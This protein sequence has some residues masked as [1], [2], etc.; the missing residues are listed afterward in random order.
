MIRSKHAWALAITWTLAALLGLATASFIAYRA[1]WR[2]TILWI[3]IGVSVAAASLLTIQLVRRSP[4]LLLTF[5]AI[6]AGGTMAVLKI[7]SLD[8]VPSIWSELDDSPALSESVRTAIGS[9][10]LDRARELVF[11]SYRELPARFS[12][13][14]ET[15]PAL[16]AEVADAWVAGKVRLGR[17]PVFD[18]PADL[19]WSENPLG[20]VDFPFELHTMPYVSALANRYD[21]THDER[22]LKR[23][24]E[25]VFDWID[26]NQRNFWRVGYPSSENSWT[27]HT[28]ALRLRHWLVFWDVWRRSP[29]FTSER[30][31][32]FLSAVLAHIR[33]LTSEDFY[34]IEHNH[35]IDQDIAVIATARVLSEFEAAP[36][37]LT[38]A[39]GRLGKQVHATIWPSGVH[40]EHSPGY[41]LYV[42]EMLSGIERFAA[43]HELEPVEKLD[44]DSLLVKM[45]TFLAE[46]ALPDRSL[47]VI[48]DTRPGELVDGERLPFLKRWAEREPLLASVLSGQLANP[49]PSHLSLFDLDAGYAIL[50]DTWSPDDA[51]RI[52]LV[53]TAASNPGRGHKHYDDLSFI[54][55]GLERSLLVDSGS[56]QYLYQSAGR[57]FVVS[58]QAHN[59]VVVD[60]GAFLGDDPYAWN[61][62]SNDPLGHDT[63]LES[64]ADD[65]EIAVVT[66]THANWPGVRFERSLVYIRPRQLV[67]V[68]RLVSNSGEGPDHLFEQ[69]WHLDADSTVEVEGTTATVR[70]PR[71]GELLLR[72]VQWRDGNVEPEVVKGR[73]DPMQGWVTTF[74]TELAAA[75]VLVYPAKAKDALFVTTIDIGSDPHHSSRSW[76]LR[77]ADDA[78]WLESDEAASSLSIRV[79]LRGGD[80]VTWSRGHR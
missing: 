26:D 71:T 31:E 23:A 68:D 28:T 73:Q 18:V 25:L 24:E 42:M 80:A 19:D 32:I 66:A 13:T 3:L 75:P 17:G 4:A 58:P 53:L 60:R 41:H 62:R 45:S 20:R 59:T 22:Y 79:P 76:K 5:W 55:H 57:K 43:I 12:E 63:H 2:L 51:D 46:L 34:T 61:W 44:L 54:L 10:D 7:H 11:E 70:D 50:R 16:Q 52:H 9:G 69:L 48:S 64:G 74:E 40:M 37:W 1:P 77:E 8:R 15:A 29:R 30:M 49:V 6:L 47:P 35:G 27:D 21:Q 14:F 38:L 72:L 56:Y 36:D 78:V 39:S 65:G 67:V 33:L